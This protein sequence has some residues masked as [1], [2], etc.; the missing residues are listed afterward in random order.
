MTEKELT[1]DALGIVP[2]DV[3]MQMGYG[4]SAPDGAIR[5]E[6]ALVIA[7]ARAVLRPRFCYSVVQSLPEALHPSRIISRQLIGSEAYALFIATAGVEYSS[8]LESQKR[9]GDILSTFIADALGSV[10]AE[11]CADAMERHLQASIDKLSWH[12]T[13]RFSP[14]YCGWPVSEQQQLF[15]LFN[16]HTCGVTLTASSLMLPEK[17]VSG[18]IGLGSSVSRHDYLCQ[19]GKGGY[20]SCEKCRLFLHK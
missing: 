20:L 18:I 7:A 8:F 19:K 5:S 12:H 13:N 4:D 14:G 11:R 9:R 15:P 16:G 17:S 6:T 3:Y 10:V 1:F 2:P